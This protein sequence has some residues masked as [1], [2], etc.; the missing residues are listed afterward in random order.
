MVKWPPTRGS[1]CHFESPG[2]WYVQTYCQ[3]LK[4]KRLIS[5]TPYSAP[6]QASIFLVAMLSFSWLR[7][8]VL[9]S[10]LM[11]NL[12]DLCSLILERNLRQI[13]QCHLMPPSVIY[14]V[15][16]LTCSIVHVF[17]SCSWPFS[18]CWP[19][20]SSFFAANCFHNTDALMTLPSAQ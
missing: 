7:D 8:A 4:Q 6:S 11:W 10:W 13:C 16:L 5:R 15:F 1:R 19:Y 14:S 12:W 9:L 17:M 18:G 2:S 20:S 3:A